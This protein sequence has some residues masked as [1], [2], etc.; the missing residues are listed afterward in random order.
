[1][2]TLGQLSLRGEASILRSVQAL[3]VLGRICEGT[4]EKMGTGRNSSL[5]FTGGAV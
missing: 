1:M 5:L 4:R 2:P 3:R